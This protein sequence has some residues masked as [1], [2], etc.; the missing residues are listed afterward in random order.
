MLRDRV[1]IVGASAAGVTA[2]TV[3]RAEGHAGDIVLVGDES[4]MPYD[5]PPLSKQFLDGTWEEDRLA[6][7]NADQV[8]DAAID[9]RLG[10]RAVGVDRAQRRVLTSAG[11]SIEYDILVIATGVRA[12]MPGPWREVP[13][14]L[15]LRTLD[16]ARELRT[17]LTT[18]RRV[19]VVGAGFVG[20]EAAAS[21][22][23]RGLDVT[24]V[25]P[26]P[27]PMAGVLPAPI[28]SMLLQTHLDHGVNVRCGVSVDELEF[29]RT[30]GLRGVR[31]SDGT[32]EAAALVVVGL[33]AT[34]NA[35][36]LDGSGLRIDGGVWC[37]EFCSAGPGIYAAGDIASWINPRFGTRMR[38]EHRLHAS[39][40]AAYVA[41]SI[42]KRRDLEPFA[43]IPFFWSDQFDVRL[44]AFGY[45]SPAHQ[46][47]VI[48]G[49][50]E[51]RR[52]VA[53]CADEG[54]I[55]GVIGAG[56][57]RQ[58]RAARA[59]VTSTADETRRRPIPPIGGAGQNP[60]ATGNPTV[61]VGVPTGS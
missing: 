32:R 11:G 54:R 47:R 21:I 56:M 57:P 1:V 2:A 46:P 3:L 29:D 16:H 18:A 60:P 7:C 25:D 9:L 61:T 53:T 52:F 55:T 17:R 27:F 39:E 51:S 48:E 24:L 20:A 36:W 30:G 15:A 59:L 37:D 5:R 31:L 50:L 28:A 14:V 23:T 35:D 13:G 34:P 43:P 41:R 42:V 33:G 49:S 45:L 19:V 38:I 22:A 40:Q 10:V 8:R 26:L 4:D 6:L 12:R 58:T 44:Q